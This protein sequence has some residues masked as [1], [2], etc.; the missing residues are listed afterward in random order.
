MELDLGGI[1]GTLGATPNCCGAVIQ[2]VEW[3]G[4]SLIRC[5]EL[6][7]FVF[8]VDCMEGA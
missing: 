6:S 2:L 5:L 7:S 4:P 8:D 3:A 1:W